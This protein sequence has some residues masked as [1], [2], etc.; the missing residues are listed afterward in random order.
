MRK[1]CFLFILLFLIYPC[2]AEDHFVLGDKEG[3]AQLIFPRQVMEGPDGN[4]YIYDSHSFYI[5]VFSP[6]GGFLR[7]MGGKGEGP[8]EIKRGDGASFN[9]TYDKKRLYFTEYFEGHRWITFMELS[10]KCH[11]VLKLKAGKN[12]A[13]SRSVQLKDRS[14]LAQV[15]FF[16]KPEKKREYFLLRFPTALVKI[17]PE[18][19]MGTEI[20]KT[21][22]VERISYHEAGRDVPIPFSPAFIWTLLK[23]NS[24]VFTE[25]LSNAFNVFDMSGKIVGEIKTPLPEPRPVTT[26]DLE[27]WKKNYIDNFRDKRWF[28][29]N[30][31][32]IKKYTKSVHEK[33][34]NTYGMSLTPGN[35]LLIAGSRDSSS[36]GNP[37]WLT[38]LKGNTVKKVEIN[39]YGLE[40]SDHFVFA[41]IYDEDENTLILCLKRK[42]NEP[43]DLARLED[44]IRKK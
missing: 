14:F 37:Y 12:Y 16:Y 19:E 24:I 22:P 3:D 17:N 44:V 32:V 1:I 33:K 27:K 8:G 21:E 42:G 30:G 39:G 31:T 4:I 9:F 35:H 40:I 26:E 28:N 41:Y 10:G 2:L 43:D 15:A 25:G 5:K 23:D 29:E 18:G 34:P 38:D 20:I 13:I 6:D 36:K 11:S 7:K